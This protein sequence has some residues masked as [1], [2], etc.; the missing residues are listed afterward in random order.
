LTPAELVHY[1]A[2]DVEPESHRRSFG[3]PPLVARFF[4]CGAMARLIV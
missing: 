4:Q 1:Q 3:R 2:L